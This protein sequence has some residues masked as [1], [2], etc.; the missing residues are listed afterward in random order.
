MNN[1]PSVFPA[2]LQS[3]HEIIRVSEN[4]K[5]INLTLC[6]KKST[7]KLQKIR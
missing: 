5:R 1:N 2:P 4:D 7:A 6:D 3:L